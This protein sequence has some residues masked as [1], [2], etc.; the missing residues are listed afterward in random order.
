VA[1]FNQADAASSAT[2]VVAKIKFPSSPRE[3]EDLQRINGP[4]CAALGQRRF[5]ST[6]ERL[7]FPD[8]MLVVSGF[9]GDV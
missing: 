4:L 9:R 2:A 6:A 1:V 8:S 3:I 5:S 7:A